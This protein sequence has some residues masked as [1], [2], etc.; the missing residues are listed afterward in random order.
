MRLSGYK[1]LSKNYQIN[2]SILTLLFAKNNTIIVYGGKR[3][4]Y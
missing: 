1:F 3:N 4:M 2:L